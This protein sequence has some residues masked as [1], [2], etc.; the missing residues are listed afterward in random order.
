MEIIDYGVC[1]LSLVS[2]RKEADH[3]SQQ[4]NQLLF[5]EHYEVLGQSTDGAWLQIRLHMDESDGW[6]DQRQHHS[7]PKEYFDQINASDYRITTDLTSGILYKKNPITILLGSVVPISNSELF[8][9]EEQFAFSG[10]SKS[11]G[12]KR[13]TEFLRS[14]ALKYLNAPYL[15][16]GKSPF[17]IDETGLTQ[18]A[19]RLAGYTI[20]RD[21]AGQAQSGKVVADAKDAR[22]GDLVVG[23]GAQGS[24]LHCGILLKDQKV[25]H[26]RGNVRIDNFEDGVVLDFESHLPLFSVLHFRRI[27]VAQ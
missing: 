1:R 10:E 19:Y 23:P 27:V 12:Q 18:M 4:V 14:V 13:D 24:D 9:M 11:L 7:I 26:V 22:A 20:A 21:V 15:S 5:G 3:R 8:R 25:L 17:G 2:V 6:L 16:G